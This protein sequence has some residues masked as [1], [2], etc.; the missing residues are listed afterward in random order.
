VSF[1]PLGPNG[2]IMRSGTPRTGDG[3]VAERYD[4]A[5]PT[6]LADL[7]PLLGEYRSDELAATYRLWQQAGQ[8]YFAINDN[9]PLRIFPKAEGRARWNAKDMLWIGFGEVIFRRDARNR[10]TGLTIGDQRV[11]GIRLRK[12]S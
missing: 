3:F 6:S 9:A 11:S 10:V 12:V 7:Q 5:P 8:V 2:M 1:E 4:P